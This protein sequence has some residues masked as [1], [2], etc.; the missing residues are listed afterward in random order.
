MLLSEYGGHVQLNSVDSQGDPSRI[1]PVNTAD[2]V[3]VN[4]NANLLSQFLTTLKSSVPLVE[5]CP[6]DA[7]EEDIVSVSDSLANLLMGITPES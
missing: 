4:E 7:E 6:M 2:D 3:Y 1:F 5:D